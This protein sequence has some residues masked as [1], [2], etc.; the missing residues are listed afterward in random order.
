MAETTTIVIR[1]ETKARLDEL[2][3]H[4]RESYNDVVDRLATMA[5]DDEPLSED[6]LKSDEE[7]E[8]ELGRG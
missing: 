3:R 4:P 6:T 8:A 5:T 7:I 1:R 2:K